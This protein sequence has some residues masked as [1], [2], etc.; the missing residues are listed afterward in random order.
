M[1]FFFFLPSF[2]LYHFSFTFFCPYPVGHRE[3]RCRTTHH[4]AAPLSA[5]RATLRRL[6]DPVTP[7]RPC[8]ARS[9][10][11]SFR[12]MFRASLVRSRPS[13]A[14]QHCPVA[15]FL[16]LPTPATVH[17]PRSPVPAKCSSV[18][19]SGTRKENR[20]MEPRGATFFGSSTVKQLL[21]VGFPGSLHRSC[22]RWRHLSG[23]RQKLSA[24]PEPEPS[25]TGPKAW[26]N[27]RHVLT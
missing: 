25:Q 27:F 12:T 4:P 13:T 15:L 22:S 18:G 3:C 7:L 19:P 17:P 10:R 23:L 8:E 9:S 14:A 6:A 26:S 5:R 1:L 16:Y 2:F 11:P 20:R 21:P 24:E